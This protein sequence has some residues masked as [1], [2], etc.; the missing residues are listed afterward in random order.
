MEEFVNLFV[1][2]G[3]A[4][5]VIIY[6]MWRDSKFMDKLNNSLTALITLVNEI[7]EREE[8]END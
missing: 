1:N 2:N 8:K 7:K 5:A 4:I 6:F 3:T